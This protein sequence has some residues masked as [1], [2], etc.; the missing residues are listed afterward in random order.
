MLRGSG[1]PAALIKRKNR[2]VKLSLT[3]CIKL[4]RG[5]MKNAVR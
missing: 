2:T 1:T 5:S 3:A 4:K